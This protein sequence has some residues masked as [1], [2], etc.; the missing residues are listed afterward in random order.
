M[1]TSPALWL[2]DKLDTQVSIR[3]CFSY[4]LDADHSCAA[5]AFDKDKVRPYRVGSVSRSYTKTFFVRSHT[6]SDFEALA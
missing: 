1:N 4:T 3:R 6:L 2:S 5:S